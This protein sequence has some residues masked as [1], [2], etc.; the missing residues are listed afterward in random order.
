MKKSLVIPFALTFAVLATGCSKNTKSEEV[1]SAS[2]MKEATVAANPAS[3]PTQASPE[4]KGRVFYMNLFARMDEDKSQSV[5]LNE[6]TLAMKGH[7]ARLVPE[8]G[9]RLTPQKL[10]SPRPM[11]FRQLQALRAAAPVDVP[12]SQQTASVERSQALQQAMRDR[13]TNAPTPLMVEVLA[14]HPEKIREGLTEPEFTAALGAVF[15]RIDINKDQ[16]VNEADLQNWQPPRLA[17]LLAASSSSPLQ[18]R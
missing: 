12:A 11:D 7:F 4:V 17:P 14:L 5:S 16:Q 18:A 13:L 3:V 1:S 10:A 2:T 9:G 6:F 8:Q 15:A